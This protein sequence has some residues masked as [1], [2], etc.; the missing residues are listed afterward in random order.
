MSFGGQAGHSLLRSRA[1][2]ILIFESPTGSSALKSP[3]PRLATA[4]QWRITPAKPADKARYAESSGLPLLC[5]P[6]PVASSRF[7]PSTALAGEIAPPSKPLAH[8]C[9]VFLQAH[10]WN[11]Y[12]LS[13]PSRA[14]P[15]SPRESFWRVN[16]WIFGCTDACFGVLFLRQ[17]RRTSITGSRATSMSHRRFRSLVL[18]LPST[19]AAR[20]KTHLR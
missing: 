10:G 1:L 5:S 3:L 8:P 12:P 18:I 7:G 17:S 14:I 15:S 13:L 11:S 4:P 6:T 9:S 20:P 16:F 19:T 2:G